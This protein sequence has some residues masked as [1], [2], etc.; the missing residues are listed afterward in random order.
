MSSSC[1][2]IGENTGKIRNYSA[3][4]LIIDQYIF[5]LNFGFSNKDQFSL[6]CRTKKV[7]DVA[8]TI[9]ITNNLFL[10]HFHHLNFDRV[11]NQS[12]M[13]HLAQT[14]TVQGQHNEDAEM[15]VLEIVK[16]CMA[17]VGKFMRASS[18]PSAKHELC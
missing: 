13:H 15:I 8:M 1:S 4:V 6:F 12:F 5:R 10:Q 16:S 9:R 14:F 2:P 11:V 7:L 18:P 17:L 3:V